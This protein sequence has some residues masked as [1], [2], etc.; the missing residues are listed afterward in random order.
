MSGIT[1]SKTGLG[2]ALSNYQT[3]SSGLSTQITEIQKALET[4]EKNWTGPEHNAAASDRTNAEGNMK[5]AVTILGNMEEAVTKLS[6]NA[7]KIEYNG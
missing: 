6:A 2:T 5:E 3:L 7:N 4:I 1:V